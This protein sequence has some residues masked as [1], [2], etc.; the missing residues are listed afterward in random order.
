MA[1]F[2]VLG[3]PSETF[4]AKVITTNIAKG[5]AVKFA[6]GGVTPAGDGDTVDGF[7]ITT[8]TVGNYVTCV[9][10]A[11]S[12]IGRAAAAVDFNVGD[13]VYIA[14]ATQ[15][16][17]TGS[18]GNKSVGV[19]VGDDPASAGWVEFRFDPLATFTHA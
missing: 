10:G 3:A 5:D 8:A 7:A 18:V 19:V 2:L 4:T 13:Q 17:D 1:N 15:T 16:L 9:R 11:M 12:V 6:A 14:A